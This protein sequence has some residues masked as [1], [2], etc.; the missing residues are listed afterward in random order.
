[1]SLLSVGGGREVVWARTRELFY[2]NE[3]R[4]R[5]LAVSVT[6]QPTLRV[7]VPKEVLTGRFGVN[8]AGLAPRPLYDV[9]PD[10]RRF[11]T[12]QDV[13]DDSAKR[14]EPRLVVVQNWDQELKRLVR[15]N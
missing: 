6:T 8:N 12:L 3:A 14:S 2:R 4:D 9:T 7:G 5:L 11:L 10:G 13:A 15:T 1:M